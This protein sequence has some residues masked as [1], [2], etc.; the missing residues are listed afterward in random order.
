M[1]CQN[2]ATCES[3]D[4]GT[5]IKYF[6]ECPDFYTGEFC[7]T[8]YVVCADSTRCF[9]G[10]ECDTDVDEDE[11]TT[12]CLCPRRYG[13]KNCETRRNG[14]ILSAGEIVG[15]VIGVFAGLFVMAVLVILKK[16]AGANRRRPRDV[17]SA[18]GDIELDGSSLAK[19][20]A[21]NGNGHAARDAATDIEGDND[22]T[23]NE[24][25]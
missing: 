11:D 13:G 10:G 3:S 2:G 1:V 6:C 22:E 19:S 25:I 23:T 12:E 18:V 17:S 8:P 7:E 21:A 14:V 24:L 5:Q 20:S 9:N 15:I 16:T 4:T